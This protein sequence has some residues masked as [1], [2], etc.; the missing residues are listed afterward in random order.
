[1]KSRTKTILS[2]KY[3]EVELF[4]VTAHGH[5]H[6]RR[7]KLSRAEQRKQNE[8]HAAKKA[9]PADQRQLCA[10]RYYRH[11]AIPRRAAP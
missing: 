7:C 3:L 5:R 1:M 8:K 10:W 6:D 9:C 2:G 4:P 11:L